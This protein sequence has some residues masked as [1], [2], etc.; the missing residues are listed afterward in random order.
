VKAKASLRIPLRWKLV[1]LLTT[2]S[3]VATGITAA[4]L[5]SMVTQRLTEQLR[6]KSVHYGRQLQS[7]LST[8][9]AFND[10]LTAA[11]V[12]DS[13]MDD[14][15]VDGL[16]V[17]RADGGLLEG[18]G[19]HPDRLPSINAPLTANSRRIVALAEIKSR[20]GKGGRVYVGLSTNSIRDL[21]R[22]DAYFEIGL[23]TGVTICA[24]L[25]AVM[26]SNRITSRIVGV[27]DA[28]K[29]FAAGDRNHPELDASTSDEVGALAGAFNLMVDD[30]NRLSR[31]HEKLV[32]TEHDR[33]ENL[34]TERTKALEQSREMFRLMAESTKATPFTLDATTGA[35][36]YA[37]SQGIDRFNIPEND[38]LR[39]GALERAFPRSKCQILRRSID[40]CGAGP[41]EF[42][43]SIPQER[44]LREFRWTGTCEF[45]GDRK[46]LRGLMLDVTEVR[47]MA[48]E[49][50]AAQKLESVGR[51]AA[52]VAHEINTP[53]QF[54]SDNVGFVRSSMSALGDVI[55]VYR[56]LRTAL[57]DCDTTV[58][59]TA[60]KEVEAVERASDLDYVLENVPLALTEALG[61]LER[62]ATIVRSMKEFA[63]PDQTEKTYADLNNA[64]QSTLVIARNEYK[65]VAEVETHFAEL[66]PVCC[67]LGEINQVVLN[68]LVNSAHA[69]A[70]FVKDSGAL[71][72]LTVRTCLIE[73]EVEISIGD[74]GSGIPE[75]IREKIFDP[76]F[77]TKE[78]GKGTGQGLALARNVI[79]N[80][81]GGTIR[82]ESECGRGTTFFI[83]IPVNA[84][85]EQGAAGR[86]A[87]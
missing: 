83:R 63:H 13:L 20:D 34:V 45:V 24:F 40:E 26:V 70:D 68:L 79:V 3:V 22:R 84:S 49:L 60:E 21:E 51:L 82:F 17:Y 2:L 31:E 29:R 80:K 73:D 74:T 41:F 54:V 33:L 71:G 18:R 44:T 42:L 10:R 32:A 7:Q 15:D 39:P 14:H 87:A 52:G 56:R 6:D 5:G 50:T 59:R 23:A 64:I 25:L 62:I 81:H 75:D 12:F 55:S 35:F 38:W 53:V 85:A 1:W 57:A 76:F 69:I 43:W 48:R 61:G 37:G 16:G 58:V 19:M 86:V 11:E 8:V 27:A 46:H 30:L 4:T 9:I 47:Q 36:I 28:A 67:Y 65:Y 72:K 78:V 66:P 77:T